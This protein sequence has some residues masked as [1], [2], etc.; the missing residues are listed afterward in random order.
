MGFPTSLLIMVQ[1]QDDSVSL[2]VSDI[3]VKFTAVH[4]DLEQILRLDTGNNVPVI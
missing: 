4:R 1:P 2:D 3:S